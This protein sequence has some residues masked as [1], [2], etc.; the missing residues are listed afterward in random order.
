MRAAFTTNLTLGLI[1]LI[2]FCE[3]PHHEVFSSLLIVIHEDIQIEADSY[4]HENNFKLKSS[5][6][7]E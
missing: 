1:T 2:I 4:K 5:S 6:T 3:A 7:T